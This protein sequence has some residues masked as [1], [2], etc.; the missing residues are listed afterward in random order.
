MGNEFPDATCS[1]DF[2][3]Y[4]VL[5]CSNMYEFR[6]NRNNLRFMAVYMIGYWTDNNPAI[7]G[8]SSF[9]FKEGDNDPAM[10]IGKCSPI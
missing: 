5:T 9:K 1:Q 10:Q 7:P 3:E 2:N 6:F 4:G 8:S